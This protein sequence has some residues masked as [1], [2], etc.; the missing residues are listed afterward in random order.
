VTCGWIYSISKRFVSALQVGWCHEDKFKDFDLM[1]GIPLFRYIEK[2]K[3]FLKSPGEARRVPGVY[4][5][6]I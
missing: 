2:A 3:L 1:E 6:Y 5:L 4:F